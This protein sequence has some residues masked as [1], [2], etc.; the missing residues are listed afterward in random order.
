[1]VYAWDCVLCFSLPEGRM[2]QLTWPSRVPEGWTNI[3][4]RLESEKVTS[5]PSHTG[6]IHKIDMVVIWSMI[7]IYTYREETKFIDNKGKYECY[8]KKKNRKDKEKPSPVWPEMLLCR[9][10]C[11][12]YCILV[13]L[14]FAKSSPDVHC[15]DTFFFFFFFFFFNTS[16]ERVVLIHSLGSLWRSV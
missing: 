15:F 14:L 11:G 3:D 16:C 9:G 13:F 8:E 5:S 10:G 4:K 2:T 12:N 6:H 7:W 1:M